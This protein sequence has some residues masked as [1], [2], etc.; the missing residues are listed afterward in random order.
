MA[1]FFRFFLDRG[2]DVT[3]FPNLT[4]EFWN[5]NVVKVHSPLRFPRKISKKNAAKCGRPR[6]SDGASSMLL[7]TCGVLLV[8]KW[9]FFSGG[10]WGV[11]FVFPS[12][13]L[14]NL[15][16]WRFLF[17]CE[18]CPV[19]AE[20]V[21]QKKRENFRERNSFYVTKRG[22]QSLDLMSRNGD[23]SR[24]SAPGAAHSD[25]EDLREKL[26]L[27]IRIPSPRGNG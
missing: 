20:F 6:S 16:S 19:C 22:M 26:V 12:A 27:P 25:H 24:E 18:F 2:G 15:R 17:S 13:L 8:P 21:F 1:H 4:V 11:G 5:Y 9:L 23:S 14:A 10:W 7:V 3:E